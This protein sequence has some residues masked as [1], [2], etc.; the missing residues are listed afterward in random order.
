[1]CAPR[2]FCKQADEAEQVS[3]LIA[4]SQ[5][6]NASTRRAVARTKTSAIVPIRQL[7]LP[8]MYHNQPHDTFI[9]IEWL[10]KLFNTYDEQ[11]VLATGRRALALAGVVSTIE[12]GNSLK[13]LQKIVAHTIKTSSPTY[14]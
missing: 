2:L 11:I 6:S 7:F 10:L 3:R 13:C 1:M 14:W 4:A 8:F 12:G 5:P 9:S